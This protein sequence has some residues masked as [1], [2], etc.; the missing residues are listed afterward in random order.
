M[1]ASGGCEYLTKNYHIS[2]FKLDILKVKP[3]ALAGSSS[4]KVACLMQQGVASTRKK[5]STKTLSIERLPELAARGILY[6]GHLEKER[7]LCGGL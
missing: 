1:L 2:Y 6:R 5:N 4:V 7:S 3:L